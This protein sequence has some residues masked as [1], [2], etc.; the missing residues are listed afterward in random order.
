MSTATLVQAQPVAAPVRPTSDLCPLTSAVLQ[1][2]V[3][4]PFIGQHEMFHVENMGTLAG[5]FTYLGRALERKEKKPSDLAHAHALG[6]ALSTAICGKKRRAGLHTGNST[7][8]GRKPTLALGNLFWHSG[9]VR[10][11]KRIPC[12]DTNDFKPTSYRMRGSIACDSKSRAACEE[13]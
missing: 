12:G 2:P 3:R 1:E 5:H 4:E 10:P 11:R 8:T 6:G 7:K 9:M 13:E